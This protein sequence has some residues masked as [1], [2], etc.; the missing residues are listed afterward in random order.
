MQR[1]EHGAYGAFEEM[2]TSLVE[3]EWKTAKWPLRNDVEG[4]CH[5]LRLSWVEEGAMSIP[6]PSHRQSS[7]EESLVGP[8][9]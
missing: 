7:E 6:S 5:S 8:Q 2:K 9:G 4:Y 1:Y 3:L